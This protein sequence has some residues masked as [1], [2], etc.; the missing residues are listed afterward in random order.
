MSASVRASMNSFHLGRSE[1]VAV[2]ANIAAV[3]WPD[4]ADSTLDNDTSSLPDYAQIMPHI[5]ED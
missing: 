3:G 1:C 5:A 2:A 4:P